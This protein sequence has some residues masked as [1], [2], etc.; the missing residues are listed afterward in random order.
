VVTVLPAEGHLWFRS[1]PTR[2][3]KNIAAPLGYIGLDKQG[4]AEVHSTGI[5][6]EM[7]RLWM[8]LGL[9]VCSRRTG[10]V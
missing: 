4:P 9:G 3:F 7:Y 10:G 2:H 5:W 8:F 6:A 1:L